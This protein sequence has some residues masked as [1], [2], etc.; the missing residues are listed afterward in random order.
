MKIAII[1]AGNLGLSIAKGLLT[2]NIITQ[3]YLTKRNTSSISDWSE[4]KNTHITDDNA[5]A[6]SSSDV[7]IFA[8]Q[9]AGIDLINACDLL[10]HISLQHTLLSW[11]GPHHSPFFVH[12]CNSLRKFALLLFG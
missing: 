11:L 9:P 2:N 3:L 7:I 12:I 5:E 10:H 8:V 4:Y 1:G 6:I